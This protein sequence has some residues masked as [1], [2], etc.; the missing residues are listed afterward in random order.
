[1]SK[2]SAPAAHAGRVCT[3]LSCLGAVVS[4]A[5]NLAA[6]VLSYGAENFGKTADGTDIMN[7]SATNL[8]EQNNDS[9][10]T[11]CTPAAN[12]TNF[13]SRPLSKSSAA[14]GGEFDDL[15]V[16]VPTSILFN[17]MVSAGKL[18]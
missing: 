11:A 14:T 9:E 6:V 1:M 2:Y 5:N 15:L 3:Q 12:C 13:V 16:W 4:L 17:R 7:S 18:P 10:F 8:D